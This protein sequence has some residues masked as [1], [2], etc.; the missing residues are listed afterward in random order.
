[1]PLKIA[2]KSLLWALDHPNKEVPHTHNLVTIFDELKETTVK[3]LMQLHLTQKGLNESP[4][5]FYSNRYSME[6][7]VR[8]ISV[9]EAEFLRLLAKL[10]EEKLNQTT[11]DHTLGTVN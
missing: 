3:S 10:L 4:S 1:M 5:P 2:M 6:H 11:K 9:Y 8:D 7:S